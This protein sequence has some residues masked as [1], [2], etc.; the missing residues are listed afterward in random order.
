MQLWF[1]VEVLTTYLRSRW[2]GMLLNS[3]WAKP[4]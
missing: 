3:G 1:N 2:Q 4:S